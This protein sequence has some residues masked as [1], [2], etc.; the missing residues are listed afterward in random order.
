MIII[1][2]IFAFLL[3]VF[4]AKC[5]IENELDFGTTFSLIL[6]YVA[7]F[8]SISIIPSQAKLNGIGMLGVFI[9]FLI[10]SAIVALIRYKSRGTIVGSIALC[11][12]VG[13]V[14][15]MCSVLIVFGIGVK[16]EVVY[17]APLEKLEPYRDNCPEITY[18]QFIDG[19]SIWHLANNRK[20]PYDTDLPPTIHR[21]GKGENGASYFE[22]HE[23]TPSPWLKKI[24][25]GWPQYESDIY[26]PSDKIYEYRSFEY[27]QQLQMEAA[28]SMY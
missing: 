1:L 5:W 27:M 10:S 19:V 3:T 28:S 7:V 2:A 6:G 18:L 23:L 13:L 15:S 16:D 24:T 14:V 21:T 17:T 20:C 22:C 26:V 12:C 9:L 4:F 25:D 11:L 8:V